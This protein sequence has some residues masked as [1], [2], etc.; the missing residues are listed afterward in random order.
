MLSQSSFQSAK[1][2][3]FAASS[4]VGQIRGRFSSSL[5][6]NSGLNSRASRRS[7]QSNALRVIPDSFSFSSSEDSLRERIWRTASFPEESDQRL[8]NFPLIHREEHLPITELSV[9]SKNA[10]KKGAQEF[11]SGDVVWLN[12][13][14][15]SF[16][17]LVTPRWKHCR[18]RL[19][20]TLRPR[21]GRE[22]P[23]MAPREACQRKRATEPQWGL[24][25]ARG[26]RGF[27]TAES[28]VLT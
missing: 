9:A 8:R 14:C 21:G 16:N 11:S 20:S 13:E 18:L 1:S 23:K 7:K 2:G 5:L 3:N 27:L 24:D 25:S 17:E 10:R 4:S 19:E 28:F 26:A 6:R 15:G 22:A 12:D